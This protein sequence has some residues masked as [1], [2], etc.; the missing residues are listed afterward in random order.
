MKF[1]KVDYCELNGYAEESG[2]ACFKVKHIYH[3]RIRPWNVILSV[4]IPSVD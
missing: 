2:I 1:R 4:S 3:P